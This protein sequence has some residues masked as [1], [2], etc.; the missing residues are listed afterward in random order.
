MARRR[1]NNGGDIVAT[2]AFF[3][4]LIYLPNR[5]SI[6]AAVGTALRWGGYL[7]VISVVISIGYKMLKLRSP[8]KTA[9]ISSARSKEK[10]D[11]VTTRTPSQTK[12]SIFTQYERQSL[13]LSEV[14]P[15]LSI[16]R[17]REV[18]WKRF[19]VL[20]R[21]YFSAKG[22]DARLTG[23]GA[24]GGVDVVLER[25]LDSGKKHKVYVQC[26]AWSNQ[27]V[28]V[29]A[30]RELYGVMAADSVKVGIFVTSSSFT[31]D[32]KQFAEGKRL[33][34]IA[35]PRL[36]EM[37]KKLPEDKQQKLKD[38]L[39]TGDYKTPTC[40]ACDTKM[41]LRTSSKGKNKGEQF[42][43]C[44]SFPKCRQMLHAKKQVRPP[45]YF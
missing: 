26:K 44:S 10:K 2:L 22:F 16:E 12:E 45:R 19:E 24:D 34:L 14:K 8:R 9:T 6:D 37:V 21:S 36:L 23:K 17:L 29:K 27:K 40:P 38:E 3:L 25:V 35:G 33:H 43:G 5:Q 31:E 15:D 32:A 20:C 28:G 7:L 1:K 39:F 30:V 11:A 41:V 42:W 18:D 4:I 13:E